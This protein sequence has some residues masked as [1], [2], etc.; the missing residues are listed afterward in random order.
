MSRNRIAWIASF[1]VAFVAFGQVS[2]QDFSIAAEPAKKKF[3]AKI[4]ELSAKLSAEVKTVTADY[5]KKLE[6]LIKAATEKGDLDK[7]LV[8]R[9]EKEWIEKDKA[10]TDTPVSLKLVQ[11]M[12]TAFEA[13]KKVATAA[14]EKAAKAAQAELITDLDAIV[15]EETKAGRLE[16]ALKVRELK[17]EIEKTVPGTTTAPPTLP[18]TTVKPAVPEAK[19][20]EL[21]NGKDLTGWKHIWSTNQKWE[22]VKGSII[23]HGPGPGASFLITEGRNY[24]NFHLRLETQLSENYE[25]QIMI[26]LTDKGKDF[27]AYRVGIAGTNPKN[28]GSGTGD[29]WF[30]SGA[31]A[32]HF[33]KKRVDPPLK[34]K[35]GEWMKLE[36]LVQGTTI[37]VVHNGKEVLK[38]DDAKALSSGAIGFACQPDSTVRFRKVEVRELPADDK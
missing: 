24:A 10:P 29:V 37:T 1:A 25:T 35:P 22:V 17:Q 19:W 33:G 13:K 21:F 27:E 8:Y 20:V 26:R 31:Y 9:A 6:E 16:S 18:G 14:Y 32:K 11:T 7:V 34:V 28:P 23:G 30:T 2:A 4:Q 5:A 36:V 12:R 38:Y 3:D 15:K